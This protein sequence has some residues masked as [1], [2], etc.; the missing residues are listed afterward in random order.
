ME[1][2]D[3][4][5]NEFVVRWDTQL[6]SVLIVHSDVAKF[7][8]PLVQIRSETLATMNWRDASQFI[9]ERLILLMPAL[10]DRYVD[11]STG[12]LPALNAT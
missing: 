1:P 2:T 10:R 12:M 5:S 6:A 9:G 11:P 3:L 4:L 8:Q 7:P